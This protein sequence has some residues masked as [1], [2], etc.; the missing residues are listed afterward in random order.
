MQAGRWQASHRHLLKVGTDCILAEKSFLGSCLSHL[1]QRY[2][3]LSPRAGWQRKH[4]ANAKLSV[5]RHSTSFSFA[6]IITGNVACFGATSGKAFFRGI[7]AE[8]FCAPT[9]RPS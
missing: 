4:L 9:F 8:R 1:L 3:R 6:N 2:L 7:A 5:R